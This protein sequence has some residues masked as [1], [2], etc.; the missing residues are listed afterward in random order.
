MNRLQK[1]LFDTLGIEI[2]IEAFP[3]S[4]LKR[5]PFFLRGMYRFQK[6]QL[7]NREIILLQQNENEYLTADQYLKQVRQ[8]EE[9]CNLPVVLV[10]EPI[11]AY[12][13]KRL[14]KKQVA[15]IIP[16]KQMF[17]PQLLIDLKEFRYA[18][19]KK[20]DTVQPAA[21]CL[22]FYHLLKENV[23]AMNFKMI[24]ERINYT[25]MTITRA[26]IDLAEREIC[27]I[28]GRKDKRLLFNA[29]K[30]TIWAK[31]QPFLQNPVKRKIYIDE[32]FEDNLMYKGGYSALAYY[33]NIAGNANEC[34]AIA[35]TDYLFLKKNQRIRI[36]NIE[37]RFCIEIWK[38][39]PGILAENKIVDPLSLYL[40][41]KDE[42]DERVEMELEKMIE[43]LW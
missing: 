3:Q 4:N 39:P 25:Q 32:N 13:R 12:N 31:A 36:N 15:F 23:E 18:T 6:T 24:A 17:I 43:R 34:F 20:Q 16:G 1:Y 33:T 9:T 7:F 30:R 8:I 26:A 40:T 27:V 37:G 2:L 35:K 21:Q 10:L 42:K 14:I 11:E 28:E 5:L 22:L 29:D 38:Y 41:L 19:K